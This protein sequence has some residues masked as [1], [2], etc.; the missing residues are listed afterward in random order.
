MER[1]ICLT[2][3][4]NVA[5]QFRKNNFPAEAAGGVGIGLQ[6]GRGAEVREV[7]AVA[8]SVPADIKQAPR[9][10]GLEKD[11][12]ECGERSH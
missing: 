7:V 1:S 6:P 9:A 10:A 5:R 4:S 3:Q 11:P 2:V 8:V 12:L